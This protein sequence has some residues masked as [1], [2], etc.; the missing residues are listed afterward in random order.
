MLFSIVN[1]ATLIAVKQQ[2]MIFCKVLNIHAF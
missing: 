1:D 2:E